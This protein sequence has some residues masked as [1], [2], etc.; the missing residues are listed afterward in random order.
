MRPGINTASLSVCKHDPHL[1]DDVA[2]VKHLREIGFETLDCSFVFTT[3][4]D[5][6]LAQDDWQKRV[7][8]LAEAASDCGIVFSQVHIPFHGKG[9]P[10]TDAKFK[11]LGY[12]EHFNEC[13]RRAYIAAGILGAPWAVAHCLSPLD[14]VCDRKKNL[15]FNREHYDSYVELGIKNNVGTAFENMIQGTQSALR[16]RYAAHP[17]DLIE[18][19]DSYNDPMVGICWDTGHANETMLDQPAALRRI[20]KRLKC[21]HVNDNFGDHDKHLI[22]FTGDINWLE[23]FPVLAEIGYEGDCSLEVGAA[24]RRSPRDLQD[25]YLRTAYDVARYLCNIFEKSKK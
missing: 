18:F 23:I 19:V 6:I 3:H 21:L 16:V 1:M 8:K 20:G 11:T 9:S 24:I 2:M 5:F 4:P 10:A 12:E 15:D 17:D 25:V 7:E 22:P 14:L 13:T